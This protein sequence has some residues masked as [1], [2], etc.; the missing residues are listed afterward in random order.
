MECVCERERVAQF[1]IH[2]KDAMGMQ[3]GDK[4]Y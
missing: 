3:K 4:P 1:P 2:G